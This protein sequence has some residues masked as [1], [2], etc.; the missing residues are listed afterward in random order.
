M[1][2]S[3]LRQFRDSQADGTISEAPMVAHPRG[4]FLFGDSSQTSIRT[5][6][7]AP[8]GCS[9]KRTLC[10][11]MYCDIRFSPFKTWTGHFASHRNR[12]TRSLLTK[13]SPQTQDVAVLCEQ[14]SINQL[15]CKYDANVIPCAAKCKWNPWGGQTHPTMFQIELQCINLVIRN[16]R[17]TCRP[18]PYTLPCPAS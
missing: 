9:Q 16:F 2:I 3:G 15:P 18:H 6:R 5:S 12:C 4:F 13:W 8:A 10:Q 7:H 14:D 11:A 17:D 1:N